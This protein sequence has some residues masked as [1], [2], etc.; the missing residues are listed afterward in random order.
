MA[1]GIKEAYADLFMLNTAAYNMNKEELVGKFKTLTNGKKSDSTLKQMVNTFINLCS[2]ADWSFTQ[3]PV[4]Q[5]DQE[6]KIDETLYSKP[7]ELEKTK[8]NGKS[9]DLNYDIHIHLPATRDERVYDALFSG[10]AKH[11]PLSR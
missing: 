6:Q 1:D 4:N 3:V 9:F 8:P 5:D 11:I 2:Y 10:L 7:N